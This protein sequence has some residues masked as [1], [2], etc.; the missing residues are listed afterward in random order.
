MGQFIM[1]L[2]ASILLLCLTVFNCTIPQEPSIP[3][4]I[5]INNIPII[6]GIYPTTLIYPDGTEE[7]Y[8]NPSYVQGNSGLQWIRVVP[9]PYLI[10]NSWEPSTPDPSGRPARQIHFTHLPKSLS[11]VIYKGAYGK[12]IRQD[13]QQ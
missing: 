5:G 1:S 10:N 6:T 13:N 2:F 3:G 11:I 4:L 7:V 9:N 8:G 12:Q